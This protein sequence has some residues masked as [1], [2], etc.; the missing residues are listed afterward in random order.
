[1]FSQ[2]IVG[3]DQF[4][5]MP[6]SAQALYFHLGIYADDDGFISPH[7]IIRM[8][9][10]NQDDLKVLI[11]KSFCIPFESGVIVITNW[12]E[13]NYIQKDRYTPTIHQTEAKMLDC[14]QNVYKML[15][16]DRLELGKVR[17]RIGKSKDITLAPKG[18]GKR[19][20]FSTEGADVIKALE[21]VDPKNKTYYN[22]TTQRSAAD[23]LVEQYG[24]DQVL[25]VIKILPQSNLQ[26]FCP[27]ITNPY[28][29][30]EKWGKLATSLQRLKNNQPILL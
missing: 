28:E 13:N 18:A 7:K 23:F 16:Q 6:I 30:K 19:V 20:K 12:K 1:M 17:V 26:N 24:L 3:N 10:A 9:G 14:I 11:T 2:R 25:K 15:P 5:D 22:N 29:L 8:V 4:L 21:D 27:N